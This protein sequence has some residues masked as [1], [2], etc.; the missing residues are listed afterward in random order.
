MR[1]AAR[2][3]VDGC[4]GLRPVSA[5]KLDVWIFLDFLNEVDPRCVIWLALL[6]SQVGS[7]ATS[8]ELEEARLP[9]IDC[10]DTRDLLS[11]RAGRR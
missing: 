1:A 10:F 6:R 2:D 7:A 8:S 5:E 9:L 11:D 4:A 3:D